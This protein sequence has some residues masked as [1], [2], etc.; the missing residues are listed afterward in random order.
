MANPFRNK[1]DIKTIPKRHVRADARAGFGGTSVAT[2]TEHAQNKM[3]GTEIER[4]ANAGIARLDRLGQRHRQAT[5]D[6]IAATEALEERRE[7]LEV[8]DSRTS[9]VCGAIRSHLL[10]V[11]KHRDVPV[12][13]RPE[14][15]PGSIDEK[16]VCAHPIRYG[17]AIAGAAITDVLLL[18]KT[19]EF[20][21]AS[22]KYNFLLAAGVLFALVWIAHGV[23][24]ELKRHA[25]GLDRR[26]HIV[27]WVLIGLVTVVTV[28]TL[29][30]L[31]IVRADSDLRFTQANEIGLDAT[32]SGLGSSAATGPTHSTLLWL[33]II[34]ALV[35][36]MSVLLSFQ[37]HEPA[38]RVDRQRSDTSQW[39]ALLAILVSGLVRLLRWPLR[40]PLQ[41][42]IAVAATRNARAEKKRASLPSID[43]LHQAEV[44]KLHDIDAGRH[45]GHH[46]ARATLLRLRHGRSWLDFLRMRPHLP[47]PQDEQ[48]APVPHLVFEEAKN[49]LGKAYGDVRDSISAL[50]HGSRSRALAGV[51]E[52][53]VDENGV[54][55]LRPQAFTVFG[56]PAP[57]RFQ[58]ND[59]IHVEGGGSK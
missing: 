17:I 15:I 21:G 39:M 48:H 52:N 19:F 44:G 11:R 14:A 51:V 46:W 55:D 2:P 3:Y 18:R 23:G 40:L 47:G 7:T 9:R 37:A 45:A 10:N 31:A 13:P 4:S 49:R 6:C 56:P 43:L 57:R 50:S 58:V 28:V 25:R 35:F 59:E 42:R 36:A 22:G 32:L 5:S 29:I 53:G 33:G 12:E 16:L 41:W 26:G 38:S 30:G 27:S 34:P 54:V 24:I 8:Y 1:S 20:F